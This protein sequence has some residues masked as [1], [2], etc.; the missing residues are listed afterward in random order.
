M[1]IFSLEWNELMISA[2][3]TGLLCGVFFIHAQ[4]K[5]NQLEE[6]IREQ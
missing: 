1:P 3:A 6:T 2:I 5:A 4:K